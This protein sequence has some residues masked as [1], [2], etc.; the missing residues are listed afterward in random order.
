VRDFSISL[1]NAEK[2][3]EIPRFEMTQLEHD[4]YVQINSNYHNRQTFNCI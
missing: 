2:Q 1:Y 4:I 3:M